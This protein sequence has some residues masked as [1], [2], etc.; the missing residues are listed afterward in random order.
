MLLSRDCYSQSIRTLFDY[1]Q[2][3]AGLRFVDT[4]NSILNKVV[5]VP[6]AQSQADQSSLQALCTLVIER[7]MK[8][9]T[10]VTL[11]LEE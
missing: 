11:F 3:A 2:G 10:T 4:I 1:G 8:I 9:F 6:C 7:T 5:K